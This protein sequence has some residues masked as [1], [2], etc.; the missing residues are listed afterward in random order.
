MTLIAIVILNWNGKHH[1]EKFLPSVCRY[2]A[3]PGNRIIVVDNGSTD[4]SVVFVGNA[5]PEV[6]L[7][8]FQQN[9][10]F[11]PGYHKALKLI[12]ARYFVLLNSDVEVT[13]GWL[14]PLYQAM[15]ADPELGA[16]MPKMLDYQTR[17]HFEYA[18]A[19]GGFIDRL[20]YPFCRGRLLSYVEKDTGQYD[21]ERN[22][23]WAT[24][25]CMFVRASAYF[26]AGELDEDFFAHMEEIDL[27]W[28]MKRI[29]YS[30]RAIPRS[31]VYHIGGGTLPNNNPRKLFLNYRNNLF[32]LF[33]NLPKG[34]VV[35]LILL[36]LILD[37]FSAIVYLFSG[38]PGFF[39]AVF[40]AHMAFY[41][42]IPGL[43][44]KRAR[45]QGLIGRLSIREIYPRSILWDFFIRGN[46]RFGQLEW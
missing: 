37:G 16:C 15:E 12:E 33:K 40:K 21:A 20:G 35:P 45:L 31:V 2:S 14:E 30:I 17:D 43:I 22:I 27:C 39:M 46:R 7:I 24:G 10:G 34:H 32:L 26:T 18:G 13:G 5:F 8:T 41:H 38:S 3:S 11:A 9:L 4:D 19:A 23:F 1:L 29:G 42:S 44:R 28:R 36:R 25:A 6:E